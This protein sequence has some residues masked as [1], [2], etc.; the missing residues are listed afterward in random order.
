MSRAGR[1]SP[2]QNSVTNW[3]IVASADHSSATESATWDP[4]L[5]VVNEV[6]ERVPKNIRKAV[7]AMIEAFR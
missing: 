3:P 2:S 5:I 1:V 7:L 6:W 4:D